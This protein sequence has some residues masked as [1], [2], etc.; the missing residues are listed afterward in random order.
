MSLIS[1]LVTVLVLVLIGGVVWW[2][3]TL[4][5]LP[6][7]FGKIAQIVVALIFVLVLLG[8]VFGQISIPVLR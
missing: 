2:I 3:L 1:L 8:V 5:P 6:E 4:V 7:P